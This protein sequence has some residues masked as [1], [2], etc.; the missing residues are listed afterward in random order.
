MNKRELGKQSE[1]KAVCY[2]KNNQIRVTEVNFRNRQGEIDIIG[3]DKDVLVFFEVKYRKN[4]N[5]GFPEEA[6]GIKKQLQ[7]CYVGNYYRYI[8]NIS[9]DTQIR[10]DVLAILG[11]DI[12]WYQNAFDHRYR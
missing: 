5:K 2:L 1:E 9:I 11:D 6:V 4:A 8:H 12:T 7:I 10:Y 3:Y